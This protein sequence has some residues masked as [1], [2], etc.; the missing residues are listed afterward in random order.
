MSTRTKSPQRHR[1]HDPDSPT[2]AFAGPTAAPAIAVEG[3]T[4]SYGDRQVLKGLSFT[5]APQEIFGILGP[6]GVGKT[7]SVEIIQGLRNR[8]AGTIQLLGLDPVRDRAKLR[9]VLGAQLQSSALPER[10]RVGE[11]LRLFARLAGDVVD[12]RE[13]RDTWDLGRL[14]RSAFGSLSGGERQRL[15]VA[16]ALV[17]RPQVVFLDELTQGLD[18]AARRETWRLVRRVREQGTTVV[19]VTHYMDEAEQLCDRVGVL[20]DGRLTA[21]DTPEGLIAGV[22]DGVR[23]RFSYASSADLTGLEA[24]PH[25]RRV[26]HDGTQVEIVAEPTAVVPVAAELAR[27]DITPDDFTVVRPTLEDVFVSLTTGGSR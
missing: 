19:L 5:V 9:K 20:H 16:L 4:K 24:I 27:R 7:T 2:A 11:A 14:E 12:W 22:G 3:L 8:D 10:L 13:L 21:C 23:V 25:V 15:F 17:N 1:H 6:N 18:P 26:A